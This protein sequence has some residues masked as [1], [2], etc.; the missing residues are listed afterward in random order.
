MTMNYTENYRVIW[1]PHNNT[2]KIHGL[3]TSGL[4]NSF[5]M[6][7]FIHSIDLK[8]ETNRRGFGEKKNDT[9]F[10]KDLTTSNIFS[11]VEHYVV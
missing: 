8:F 2:Y 6:F 5:N 9:I 11:L 3:L 10:Y 7:K 1:I 4:A